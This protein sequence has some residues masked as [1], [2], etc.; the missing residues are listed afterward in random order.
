[1]QI[2]RGVEWASH[3]CVLLC[4][5]PPDSGLPAAAI[6]EYFDVPPQYMAKHLQLLAAAGLVTSHR[7]RK[8]GYRLA[9][10]AN[11]I[12][13]WDIMVAVEGGAPAFRCR[14]IRQNGPCPT[15]REQCRV[16]CNIATAFHSAERAFR[17]ELD[18]KRIDQLAIEVMQASPRAQLT[19]IGSW[20]ASHS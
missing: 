10:P 8:G 2:G 20:I 12:S 1:M 14:N 5:V 17:K 19:K 3:A 15:P 7:G 13:L 16:P 18:A 6:A 9:R 4:A 11:D